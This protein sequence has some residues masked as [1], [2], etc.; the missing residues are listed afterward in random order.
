MKLKLGSRPISE[1]KMQKRY[2]EP[3]DV[4]VYK[5][6]VYLSTLSVF[7]HFLAV[8]YAFRCEQASLIKSCNK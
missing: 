8:Q 4:K 7:L 1:G 5:L 6:S 2:K 3:T